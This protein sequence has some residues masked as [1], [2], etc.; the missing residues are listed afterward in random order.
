[1]IPG[2][3]V[4]ELL[5]LSDQSQQV[6]RPLM[7]SQARSI[8]QNPELIGLLKYAIE[9]AV[10]FWTVLT[11][12]TLLTVLTADKLDI[13]DTVGFDKPPRQSVNEL[14]CC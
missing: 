14:R 9:T 1:M 4:T 10:G 6:S 5:C 11:G 2:T 7:I 3:R 8:R 12:L 13:A